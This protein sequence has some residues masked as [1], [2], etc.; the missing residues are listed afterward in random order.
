[1]LF[2]N[3]IKYE[4]NHVFCTAK[5]A[6]HIDPFYQSYL[7]DINVEK[8]SP[9]LSVILT[10]YLSHLLY[11]FMKLWFERNHLCNTMEAEIL[12]LPQKVKTV[13]QLF[14]QAKTKLSDLR[15]SDLIKKISSNNCDKSNTIQ[16]SRISNKR[17]F[18]FSTRLWQLN[19]IMHSIK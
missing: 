12:L 19:K 14:T 17:A 10:S 18:H 8:L 5:A 16:M 6:R 11:L 3:K 13:K 4:A 7:T 9:F 2:T 15:K 1:M